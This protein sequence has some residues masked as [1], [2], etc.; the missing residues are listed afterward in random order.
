MSKQDIYALV[1]QG[2]DCPVIYAYQ[3]G[4]RPEGVYATLHVR[5]VSRA[6]QDERS[7]VADDGTRRIH[8]HRDCVVELQVFGT[9]SCEV[10]ED[11]DIWTQ[12]EACGKICSDLNLA[13]FDRG[14]VTDAPALLNNSTYEQRGLYEIWIRYTKQI[15][16]A[17][18]FFNRVETQSQQV[19]GLSDPHTIFNKTGV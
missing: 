7:R 16:E 10:L 19:G 18:D 17:V 14:T 2:I 13:I 1:S 12:T 15:T 5:V 6:D 11:F 8:G 4:N 3:N 9:G